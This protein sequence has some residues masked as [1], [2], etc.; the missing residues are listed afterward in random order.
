MNN[1][2]VSIA[3]ATYN[4]EKFL[5]KQLDSIYGQTYKNIE[6]IVTDDCSTDKTVEILQEYKKN[7][8][9]KYHINDHNLGFIKNFEKAITLSNGNYVALADQDDIWLPEK[10]ETLVEK[11]KGYSL[12]CSD[13]SLINGNDE[14]MITSFNE[15]SGRSIPKDK[16]FQYLVFGNYVTGCTAMIDKEL[17]SNALPSKVVS[18]KPA[19]KSRFHS[20]ASL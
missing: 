9:L 2:L 11:I 8:G 16:V 5:Q 10:I 15:Y 19:P 18:R 3:M 7:Y 1:P 6:V 13:A 4:G 14:I 20:S 12:V 17:F